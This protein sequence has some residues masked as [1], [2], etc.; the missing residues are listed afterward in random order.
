MGIDRYMN[1]DAW[2]G[3]DFFFNLY[4]EFMGKKKLISSPPIQ[5]VG[6][7]ISELEA[8]I[9]AQFGRIK[10]IKIKK[11]QLSELFDALEVAS[12]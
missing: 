12:E 11:G 9:D 6:P 10:C 1:I 7:Y 2:M 4:L 5:M 8:N 3:K